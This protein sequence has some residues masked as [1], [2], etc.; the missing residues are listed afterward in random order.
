MKQLRAFL[1]MMFA[2]AEDEETQKRGAVGV[3]YFSTTLEFARELQQRKAKLL[4]WIPLRYG[5]AHVCSNDV[6]LLALKAFLMLAIGQRPR[7][8]LRI[9]EGKY[10]YFVDFCY[11]MN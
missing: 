1:Y 9:H 5:G 4:Q 2:M 6:R 10:I 8:R 3:F 7:A 11:Q